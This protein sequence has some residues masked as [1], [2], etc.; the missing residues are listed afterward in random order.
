MS[1]TSLVYLKTQYLLILNFFFFDLLG[2]VHSTWAREHLLQGFDHM[3]TPVTGSRIKMGDNDS[4]EPNPKGVQGSS[5]Q[6]I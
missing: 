3:Q 4:F 5:I 6:R 2:A 1:Y